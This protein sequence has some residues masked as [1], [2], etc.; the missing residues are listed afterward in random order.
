MPYHCQTAMLHIQYVQIRSSLGFFLVSV[1]ITCSLS[2]ETRAC[3]L[4]DTAYPTANSKART[5][6]SADN[7]THPEAAL[8]EAAKLTIHEGS[9]AM[10]DTNLPACTL[11]DCEMSLAGMCMCLRPSTGLGKR[12]MYTCHNQR[13][14]K[15]SW[16]L[17]A[18]THLRIARLAATQ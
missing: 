2:S 4:S 5:A 13:S 11:Y 9:V 14:L 10:S 18:C 6:H 1:Q 7:A 17:H 3:R 12:T 16:T 15:A 8:D